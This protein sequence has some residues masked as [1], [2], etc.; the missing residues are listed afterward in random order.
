MKK[1][2]VTG[3]VTMMI[4][5]GIMSG[6]MHNNNVEHAIEM[7]EMQEML[8]KS[9]EDYD[10]LAAKHQ[11]LSEY[12]DKLQVKYDEMAAEY[13]NFEDYHEAFVDQVNR[14]FNGED[15]S[16]RTTDETG[17]TTLH[18]SVNGVKKETKIN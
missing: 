8:G 17:V 11:V 9:Y 10:T 6:V 7:Q 5:A 15:Y 2:I 4:T 16:I 12:Y 1:I 13:R 18:Y 3:L 14:A